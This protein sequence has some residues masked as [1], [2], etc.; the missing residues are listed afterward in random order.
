VRLVIAQ[1]TVD[2]LGRLSA[3]LPSARRLLLIK[4]DGSVSVH[5]DDYKPLNWMS[6]PCRL[7]EETHRPLP[8]WVAETR[9]SNLLH[10]CKLRHGLHRKVR[11]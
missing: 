6:P 2:Y 9:S 4:A 3:H 11:S 7:A 1:C 10:H 8:V 5:A